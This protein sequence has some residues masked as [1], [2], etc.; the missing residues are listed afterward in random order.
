MYGTG[1]LPARQAAAKLHTW[2]V[3][4][5]DYNALACSAR[6]PRTRLRGGL[7]ARIAISAPE[8][9]LAEIVHVD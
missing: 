8:T 2:R 4:A 7:I 6:Q 9:G 1:G 5:T 3:G